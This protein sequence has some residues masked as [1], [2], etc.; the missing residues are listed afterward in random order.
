MVSLFCSADNMHI[1]TPEKEK[2]PEGLDFRTL[3]Y[4]VLETF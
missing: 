1:G 2:H 3:V 4:T